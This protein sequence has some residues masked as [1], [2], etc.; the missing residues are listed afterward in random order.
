MILYWQISLLTRLFFCPFYVCCEDTCLVKLQ[1][2]YLTDLGFSVVL[3]SALHLSENI[4]GW[5][6]LCM[7]PNCSCSHHVPLIPQWASQGGCTGTE[8]MTTVK[9]SSSSVCIQAVNTRANWKYG[10]LHQ[11]PAGQNSS[12]A[13]VDCFD[14]NLYI[15]MTGIWLIPWLSV[16]PPL[17]LTV[18]ERKSF[19]W[20][21][22]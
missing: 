17:C 20:T 8:Q 4:P 18:L 2:M 10:K 19:S 6:P 3:P 22:D 7:W 16:L 21:S 1:N 5:F 14:V 12:W 11:L 13:A 9:L 15:S